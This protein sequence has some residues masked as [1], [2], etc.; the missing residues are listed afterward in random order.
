MYTSIHTSDPITYT[1]SKRV[2]TL[3]KHIEI[4][5]LKIFLKRN[6]LKNWL[7]LKYIGLVTNC[8]DSVYCS[9]VPSV[10]HL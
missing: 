8:F 2:S 9:T 3:Q 10:A 1:L 6:S 4:K 7:V 5:Y